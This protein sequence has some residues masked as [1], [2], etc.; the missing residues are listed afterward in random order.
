MH[1][2]LYMSETL[3]AYGLNVSMVSVT[4]METRVSAA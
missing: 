3:S 1:Q 2:T 4:P